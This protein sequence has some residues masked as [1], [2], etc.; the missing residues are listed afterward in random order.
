MFAYLL[1][2]LAIAVPT[3]FGITIVTFVVMQMAPG[4]PVT[5]QYGGALANKG[6]G[7][8]AHLEAM[9]HMYK[10]D[11]PVYVQYLSWLGRIA[12]LNFGNSFI[13]N[14]PVIDKIGERLPLTIWLNVLSLFLAFLI[15]IPLGAQAARQQGQAFDRYSGGLAFIL[16]SLPVPWIALLLLNWLGVELDLFPVAGILADD[17]DELGF[18]GKIGSIVS[19]SVLPVICLTYGSIAFL[20]KLTRSSMLEVLRQD[21][22]LAAR[23]RGISRR[24]ILYNHALRNALL[25]I[26]TLVGSLIPTLISGSVIIERIFSLP[27]IGQLFFESVLYRDYT[28]IMG[29]SVLSAALTLAGVLIADI[30]YAL[31]DPRIS[32]E[33]IQ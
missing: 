26:I 30:V 5:M 15:A 13:D 11:E 16:Y 18:F 28:T 8:K 29:L 22:I 20:A 31:V 3:L 2:R 27:G 24:R 21:Y 25:P 23:A 6:A 14:R 17:F 12:T 32:F 33:E 1:R 4:D 10:L 7:A 9:R 19:H